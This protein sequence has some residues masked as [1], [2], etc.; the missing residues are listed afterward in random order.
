VKLLHTDLNGESTVLDIAY[1]NKKSL[2]P[3]I[4]LEKNTIQ[5]NELGTNLYQVQ[6]Y[7]L[8]G[9]IVQELNVSKNQNNIP[10]N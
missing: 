10:K 8:S 9:K 7:H 6:I 3:E 2:E 5:F 4:V 1:L